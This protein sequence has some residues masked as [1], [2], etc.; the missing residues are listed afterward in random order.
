[1]T[2][3]IWAY[4]SKYVRFT[5]CALGAVVFLGAGLYGYF[6]SYGPEGGELYFSPET[7][8]YK[9]CT[10]RVIPIL[11][12][13]AGPAHEQIY[14][15]PMLRFL[16]RNGF[17]PPRENYETTWDHIPNQLSKVL[18]DG[19]E[20]LEWS[21]LRPRYARVLWPVVARLVRWGEYH[22]A[23]KLIRWT[24]IMGGDHCTLDEYENRLAL[25]LR[26]LIGLPL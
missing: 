11:E 1:M 15:T 8:T 17:I 24:V 3:R 23:R 9:T 6:S 10:Y 26:E 25:R 13:Q 5:L 12:I 16:N 14:R 22:E 19:D 7:F 2:T 21:K 20:V 4:L 18:H